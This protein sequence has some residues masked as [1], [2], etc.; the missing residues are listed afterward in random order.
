MK[1]SATIGKVGM[2]PEI[3]ELLEISPGLQRA[4]HCML[5][6]LGHVTDIPF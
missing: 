6:E 2:H 5:S 4:A 1:F 3:Y